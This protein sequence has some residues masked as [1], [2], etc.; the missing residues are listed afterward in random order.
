VV[1]VVAAHFAALVVVDEGYVTVGA[2]LDEPALVAHDEGGEAAAV[3]EEHNLL[4]ALE[5]G[6]HGLFH[7]FAEGAAGTEHGLSAKIEEVHVGEGAVFDAFGELEEFQPGILGAL[8]PPVTFEGGCSATEEENGG[9][10]LRTPASNGYSMVAGRGILLVGGLVLF[11]DDDD[12]KVL[13]GGEDGGTGADN[14]VGLAAAETLPFVVALAG[15]EGAMQDGHAVAETGL[16]APDGERGERDLGDQDDGAAPA[17]EGLGQSL[18][19]DLGLAAAGDAVEQAAPVD[20]IFKS[21]GHAVESALLRGS[22]GEDL[23]TLLES[24]IARPAL[25][26]FV[27]DGDES[28]LFEGEDRAASESGQGSVVFLGETTEDGGLAGSARGTFL[29][30]GEGLGRRD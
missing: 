1:T 14:D 10:L 29:S 15:G 19:V 8:G 5:A 9:G 20:M 7:L 2:A 23:S 22:R 27:E 13:H 6:G 24:G 30:S 25:D 16:E 3:H 21:L 17:G 11:V 28:Q 4:A 12:A 26:Q 18:E